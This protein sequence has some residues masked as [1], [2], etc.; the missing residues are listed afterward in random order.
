MIYVDSGSGLSSYRPCLLFHASRLSLGFYLRSDS[1]I[2]LALDLVVYLAPDS[3]IDLVPDL[4]LGLTP[5][6]VPDLVI[7]YIAYAS[8]LYH[9]AWT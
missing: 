1:V 5:D 6:L 7:Y 3:V 9:C 8:Y 2:D 4:A